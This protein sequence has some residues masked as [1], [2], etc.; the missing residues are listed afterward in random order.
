M[1][2]WSSTNKTWQT[3]CEN[4]TLVKIMSS[5][6]CVGFVD[7]RLLIRDLHELPFLRTG[8][9]LHSEYQHKLP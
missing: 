5:I 9:R 7:L 2:E 6:S 8:Q 1:Q 4:A 3:M